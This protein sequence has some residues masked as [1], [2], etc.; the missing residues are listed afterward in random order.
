MQIT[1]EAPPPSSFS[2]YNM[3]SVLLEAVQPH[4]MNEHAEEITKSTRQ[5]L[6]SYSNNENP[7]RPL[8]FSIQKMGKSFAILHPPW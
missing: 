2:L 1:K 5:S 6:N 7:L 8:S 3:L 4:Y